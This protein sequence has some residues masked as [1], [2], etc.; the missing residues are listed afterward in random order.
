MSTLPDPSD[1]EPL[2]TQPADPTT[3]TASTRSGERAEASPR[4]S[5][6]N[7]SEQPW[8]AAEADNS[9]DFLLLLVVAEG[10]G[11]LMCAYSVVLLILDGAAN[12]RLMPFLIALLA[13]AVA[14]LGTSAVA[15][16]RRHARHRA[17][18]PQH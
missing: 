14:L 2:G 17:G 13:A 15:D 7:P 11:C 6:E 12:R 1:A 3:G 18:R 9:E 10:V 5:P 8:R 4:R 16:Y